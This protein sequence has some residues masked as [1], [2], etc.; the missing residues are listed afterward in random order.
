MRFKF[1]LNNQ[2]K[3]SKFEKAL[4]KSF[5]FNIVKKYDGI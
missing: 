1:N 2:Y 5:L 3:E 4:K